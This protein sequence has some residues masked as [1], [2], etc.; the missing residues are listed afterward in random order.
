M[1]LKY[2]D[3]GF[4]ATIRVANLYE[5]LIFR[6]INCGFFATIRVANLYEGL[7]FREINGFGPIR[8]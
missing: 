2:V 7:I 1:G 4:F 5:G 6:E 8:M 3:C